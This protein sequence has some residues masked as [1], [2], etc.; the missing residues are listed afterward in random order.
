MV[1]AVDYAKTHKPYISEVEVSL[2]LQEGFKV[3]VKRE[4]AKI[5]RYVSE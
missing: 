3:R 5:I 4:P 1:E 2:N